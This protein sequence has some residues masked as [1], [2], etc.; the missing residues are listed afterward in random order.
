MNVFKKLQLW[1]ALFLGCAV[2]MVAQIPQINSGGVVNAA[3]YAPGPVAPGSIISIFG[4]NLAASAG[5][6]GTLPLPTDINGTEVNF[7]SYAAP[8]LGVS[9]S[10]INAQVPWGLAGELNTA[11]TVTVRGKV[12]T[13]QTVRLAPFR[14]IVPPSGCI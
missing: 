9:P 5:S 2:G 14:L 1:L 7:G 8:L 6:A 4:T 12:G 11:V 10:Q 3:S 13:P